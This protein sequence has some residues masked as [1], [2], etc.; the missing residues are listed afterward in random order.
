[1]AEIMAPTPP[2]PIIP[3]VTRAFLKSQLDALLDAIV[4]RFAPRVEVQRA[5]DEIRGRVDA[6][7]LAKPR[8]R[9]K[10]VSERALP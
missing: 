10:A 6:L 5:L 7:E 8:V 9:V 1:M 2:P 4:S 3:P